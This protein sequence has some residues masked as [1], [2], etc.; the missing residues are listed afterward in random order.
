VA[1][2]NV[3]MVRAMFDA[4]ERDGVDAMLP[5]VHEEFSG[6]VPPTMSVEPDTY[7]G[8]EGIRRYFAGFDDVVDD[9]HWEIDRVEDAGDGLVIAAGRIIG[10]GKTT[11]L[12]FALDAVTVISVRDG[13]AIRMDGHPDL[14]S[15]RAAVAERRATT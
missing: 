7:R 11:E 10:R 14:A 6:E 5:Y 2:T 8:H 4:L 1:E 12:P 3:E 9:L 15:A 13:R